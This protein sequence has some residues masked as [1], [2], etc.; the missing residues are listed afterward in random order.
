MYAPWDCVTMNTSCAV[1]HS[2][3]CELGSSA[4]VGKGL[5]YCALCLMW[6]WQFCYMTHNLIH[7]SSIASWA[8]CCGGYKELPY[9]YCAVYISKDIT[10]YWEELYI[11]IQ[12]GVPEPGGQGSWA[13][14]AA[15]ETTGTAGGQRWQL[16]NWVV[17]PSTERT[18]PNVYLL[19]L[20]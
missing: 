9:C 13:A 3:Y 1:V 15:G 18:S 8:I 6:T 17:R 19:V 14:Q 2:V 20:V 5:I 12:A 16:V 7:A 11:Q 4:M 10:V